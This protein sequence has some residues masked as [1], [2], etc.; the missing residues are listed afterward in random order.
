MGAQ[1]I[2]IDI[3]NATHEKAVE[4]AKKLREYPINNGMVVTKCKVINHPDQDDE[5][6]TLVSRQ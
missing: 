5:K 1:R 3:M 2:I 4:V 6:H